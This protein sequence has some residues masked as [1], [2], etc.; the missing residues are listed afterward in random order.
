MAV[1]KRQ[2]KYKIDLKIKL[3]RKR[4][5]FERWKIA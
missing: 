5:N 4:N 1:I 3:S 2:R